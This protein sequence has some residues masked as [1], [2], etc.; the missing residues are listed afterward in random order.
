MALALLA[1][2][3]RKRKPTMTN[4]P[5]GRDPVKKEYESEADKVRSLNKK[6]FEA[7]KKLKAAN[8]DRDFKKASAAVE[9]LARLSKDLGPALDLSRA[10]DISDAMDA[11]KQT[12]L[13]ENWPHDQGGQPCWCGKYGMHGGQS[14]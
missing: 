13:G 1:S 6:V 11:L 7:Q 8:K 3:N 5:Q 12:G 10:K 2:Y 14:R 9:E 4:G